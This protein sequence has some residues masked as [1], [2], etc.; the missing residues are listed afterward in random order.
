MAYVDLLRI[1]KN[2]IFAISEISMPMHFTAHV[3][4]VSM[5]RKAIIVGED[6]C[7]IALFMESVIA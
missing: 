5:Q 7:F 2:L 6:T 3:L 4:D 1:S